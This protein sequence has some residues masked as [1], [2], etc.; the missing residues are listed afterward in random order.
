M[1][2]ITAIGPPARPDVADFAMSESAV[3][4][5]RDISE[6]LSA[7]SFSIRFL[8]RGRWWN[9]SCRAICCSAC[10]RSC[11]CAQAN[12][13]LHPN[14]R[15][16]VYRR[17]RQWIVVARVGRPDPCHVGVKN[18]QQKLRGF[19]VPSLGFA[20]DNLLNFL[21]NQFLHSEFSSKFVSK[22]APTT[23]L[24]RRLDL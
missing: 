8:Y 20:I 11:R 23:K 3:T 4:G 12:E 5:P 15:A 17:R 7:R 10:C 24:R 19:L 16:I 14:R 18:R 21:F 9:S 1:V 13:I 2:Q 6:R 22:F